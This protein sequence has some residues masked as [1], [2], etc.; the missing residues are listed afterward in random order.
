MH[1]SV[2]QAL[3]ITKENMSLDVVRACSQPV[4]FVTAV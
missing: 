1:Q 4:Y 3:L 2:N